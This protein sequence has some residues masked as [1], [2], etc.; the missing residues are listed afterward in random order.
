MPLAT[1][2]NYGTNIQSAQALFKQ[3]LALEQEIQTHQTDLDR[4]AESAEAMQ[5][6]GHF[7]SS[8][9]TQSL[10]E[11]AQD[12]DKLKRA[13]ANRMHKLKASLRSHQYYDEAVLAEQWIK[14]KLPLVNSATETGK[15]EDSALSLVR[16]L[17]A[18]EQDVKLY[19]KEMG[20]L[21]KIVDDMIAEEHFDSEQLSSRQSQL[22]RSYEEL[23]DLCQRRRYQLQDAAKYY[24]FVRQSDDLSGWLKEK[25][26]IAASEDYG[27]D[28]DECQQLIS[29]FEQCLRELASAGERV[30]GVQNAADEM[31]R[32][33]HPYSASIKAKSA[34]LAQQW[35][36]VNE[37]ANDRLA[38]LQGAKKVHAFDN[39]ADETLHWLQEKEAQ[40]VD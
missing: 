5:K 34:D 16:K 32:H 18:L 24:A 23:A 14:Q 38:A 4:L 2:S 13:V 30:H 10:S 25:E 12:V 20:R 15:D 31:T 8:Q 9:I 17:D 6:R 39:E 7:A 19:A 33:G 40:Q 1:S 21:R 29:E 36:E 11:L 28:L 35:V 37:A 3:H 27:R 22:D 26:V